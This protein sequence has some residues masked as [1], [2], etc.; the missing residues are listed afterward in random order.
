MDSHMTTKES[1]F[2][3]GEIVCERIRP[4]QKLLVK[5]IE[6]QIYYCSALENKSIKSLVFRERELMTNSD[7]PVEGKRVSG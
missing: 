1:K 4:A 5:R 7:C 6:N 3:Q 2:K